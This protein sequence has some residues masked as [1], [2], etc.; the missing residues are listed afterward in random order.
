ME[1]GTVILD[2]IRISQTQPVVEQDLRT[3]RSG[4]NERSNSI[5]LGENCKLR[6]EN[7]ST[8]VSSKSM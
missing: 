8:N 2:R 4:C 6:P 3:S 5:R 1:F 7:L